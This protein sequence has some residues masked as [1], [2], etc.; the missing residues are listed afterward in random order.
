[1]RRHTWVLM[2]PDS[3]KMLKPGYKSLYKHAGR[4]VYENKEREKHLKSR[5]EGKEDHGHSQQIKYAKPPLSYFQ[6]PAKNATCSKTCTF[7]AW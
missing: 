2:G 3:N 1:M 4:V 7:H 5:Y 6:K